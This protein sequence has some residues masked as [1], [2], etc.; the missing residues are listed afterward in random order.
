MLRGAP[1]VTINSSFPSGRTAKNGPALQKEDCL[2]L[3]CPGAP[4]MPLGLPGTHHPGALHLP[5][6]GS[7]TKAKHGFSE[8][9]KPTWHQLALHKLRR[10][11]NWCHHSLS[12]QYIPEP[13]IPSQNEMSEA[14]SREHTE[15]ASHNTFIANLPSAKVGRLAWST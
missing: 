8:C 11:F 4:Q 13:L 15:T 10:I 14:R 12:L 1:T 6:R 9:D 7:E 3:H 2:W 5:E